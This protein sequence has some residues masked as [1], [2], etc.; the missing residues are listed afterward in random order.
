MSGLLGRTHA[1]KGKFNTFGGLVPV[2]VGP[3]GFGKT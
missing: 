2:Y 3:R 1:C